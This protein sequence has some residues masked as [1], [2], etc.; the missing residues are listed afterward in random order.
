MTLAATPTGPMASGRSVVEPEVDLDGS[1]TEE[2][3][4]AGNAVMATSMR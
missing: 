3:E 2:G 1:E 4:L